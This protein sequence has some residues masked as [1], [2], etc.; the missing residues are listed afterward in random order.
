MYVERK[1]R[2]LTYPLSS[3]LSPKTQLQLI[4]QDKH[5]GYRYHRFRG[6]RIRVSSFVAKVQPCLNLSQY[7][8]DSSH[9]VRLQIHIQWW[10]RDCEVYAKLFSCLE[11]RDSPLRKGA[12][13]SP[14]P[15]F[16]TGPES[17]KSTSTRIQKAH[18]GSQRRE[19]QSRFGTFQSSSQGSRRWLQRDKRKYHDSGHHY[20]QGRA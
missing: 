3:T 20:F 11:R 17:R 9:P 12:I 18:S 16:G 7:T 2:T 19:W 6:S 8:L 14:F 1:G 13:Q 15:R 4:L 10:H 5:D